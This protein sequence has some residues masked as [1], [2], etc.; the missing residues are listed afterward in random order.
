MDP[1]AAR[2]SPRRRAV[3]LLGVV[4]GHMRELGEHVAVVAAVAAVLGVERAR[5]HEHTRA[6]RQAFAESKQQPRVRQQH[7]MLRYVSNPD[8]QAP[9]TT[10]ITALHP[11][12]R[13]QAP[14]LF[15]PIGPR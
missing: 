15:H 11:I 8:E 3:S 10:L 2:E 7:G 13:K 6:G 5:T 9:H 1:R 14:G 12:K 4:P